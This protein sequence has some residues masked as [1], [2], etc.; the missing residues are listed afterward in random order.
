MSLYHLVL[1]APLLHSLLRRTRNGQYIFNDLKLNCPLS[2]IALHTQTSL[3]YFYYF[4]FSIIKQFFVITRQSHFPRSDFEW[5]TVVMQTVSAYIKNNLF[6]YITVG[7]CRI[8]KLVLTILLNIYLQ[9]YI[10]S[11]VLDIFW[12][13]LSFILNIYQ[14][15]YCC[16]DCSIF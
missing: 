4:M 2:C 3:Y 1:C 10:W 12:R 13:Y 6:N 14:T 7:K 9:R 11:V 5:N 15:F 8:L 16:F